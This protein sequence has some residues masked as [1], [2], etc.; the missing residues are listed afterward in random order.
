MHSPPVF[1]CGDQCRLCGRAPSSSSRADGVSDFSSA[2]NKGKPW[3]ANRKHL[4]PGRKLAAS[5]DE[6][7][8]GLT[9]VPPVSALFPNLSES[10][11]LNRNTA[12]QGTQRTRVQGCGSSWKL[13]GG[14]LHTLPRTALQSPCE[15]QAAQT[16]PRLDKDGREALLRG[17]WWKR[18]FWRFVQS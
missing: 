15:P 4:L 17:Y 13:Q 16:G 8:E 11:T 6:A 3:T 2:V 5:K 10:R 1:E 9:C 7:G 18:R 14:Y 12:G